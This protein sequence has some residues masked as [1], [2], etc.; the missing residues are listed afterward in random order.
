MSQ[1]H[2]HM[3]NSHL[4]IKT[5]TTGHICRSS[6][7]PLTQVSAHYKIHLSSSHNPLTHK[8]EH[9]S[10]FKC[11]TRQ[12]MTT[13]PHLNDRAGLSSIFMDIL[14]QASAVS[15]CLPGVRATL[16]AATWCALHFH[17]PDLVWQGVG[18]TTNSHA[19]VYI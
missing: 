17:P 15:S 16:A 8:C 2:T 11:S 18:S 4:H 6:Q 12:P 9:S 13:Q 19:L 5:C 1:H 10:M 14:W 7:N 3:A